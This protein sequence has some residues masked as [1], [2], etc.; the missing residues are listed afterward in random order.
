M[1]FFNQIRL[2]LVLLMALLGA[3]SVLLPSVMRITEE[4]VDRTGRHDIAWNG[5]NGRNEFQDL[6]FQIMAFT[7]APGGEARE[8]AHLAHEIF[9]SRLGSWR[10]GL[11]GEFVGQSARRKDSLM[12]IEAGVSESELGLKRL[13][14]PQARTAVIAILKRIEPEV[15]RIG[16]EAYTASTQQIAANTDSLRRLQNLQRGA[17]VALVATGFLLTALLF[18]QNRLLKSAHKAEKEASAENAYLA[19]HDVLTHLPNRASLHE[20]LEKAL[21]GAASERFPVLL[22]IDLDGFKPINDVLG[23]RAGDQLLTSVGERLG[24]LAEGA[25]RP[26]AARLGGDE[27]VVLYPSL[28]GGTDAIERAEQILR[29]LREP[30]RVDDHSVTIDASIGIALFEEA[31]RDPVDFLNRADIALNIAKTAGKGI[32]LMFEPAMAAG[33]VSRQK[34]EAELAEADAWAEFVP[35]YQPLVDIV[36]GEIIGVEALARWHHPARGLVPPAEFIPAAERSGRIVEIGRIM[37]EKAC[38]DALLFPRPI[39]VSVNL[40]PVQLMR[41]DVAQVIGDILHKTRLPPERLKLELTESVMVNDTKASS[42]LVSRLQAMGVFV[43]LDD[44][45]TGYSSLSYLRRFDFDEIKID[46]SFITDLDQDRQALAIVQ[47]IVALARNLDMK[48]IAEGIETEE[49]AKL[50]L[51]CGCARGQGYLFG[52]P[53]PFERVI[54]ALSRPKAQVA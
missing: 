11:F 13:D 53:L 3:T 7:V 28:A 15:E 40:S 21:A 48:V 20:A 52:K 36:S 32:I 42:E 31:N 25:D 16:R 10:N 50:V 23:H 37:I 14:D 26:F 17:I 27:F 39:A 8:R 24:A 35:Y 38:R 51:A 44:F 46:R 1:R 47:T 22:V 6:M 19:S 4:A 45:G 43:S 54:E 33:I 5:L 34:L 2:I 29:I 41:I 9:V 12:R 49:Q 30:H 18:W